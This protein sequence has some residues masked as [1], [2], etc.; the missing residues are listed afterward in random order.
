[1]FR[2]QFDGLPQDIQEILKGMLEKTILDIYRKSKWGESD[3]TVRRLTSE[4]IS[5]K[6]VSIF[7]LAAKFR[8]DGS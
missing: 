4:E 8:P 7:D 2:D 6:I 5:A 3:N 1:M